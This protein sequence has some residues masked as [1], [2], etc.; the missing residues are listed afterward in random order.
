VRIIII[1]RE[2]WVLL[3]RIALEEIYS[4]DP[5]LVFFKKTYKPNII[6]VYDGEFEDLKDM[7]EVLTSSD[8]EVP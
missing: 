4:K 6:K 5:N 7:R 3:N 1:I 8:N 2:S